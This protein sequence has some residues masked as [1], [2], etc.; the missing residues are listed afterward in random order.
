M[1][2]QPWVTI[3]T[4]LQ[5]RP[6][7]ANVYIQRKLL[8]V[9]LMT[10]EKFPEERQGLNRPF[11]LWS[12]FWPKTPVKYNQL[13]HTLSPPKLS[14]RKQPF[15]LAPEKHLPRNLLNK[16]STGTS[17]NQ[18][19]D[20]AVPMNTEKFSSKAIRARFKPAFPPPLPFFSLKKK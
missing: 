6:C 2:L 14:H 13:L 17:Y 10:R 18:K 7:L 1:H 3:P 19:S 5:R 16:A 20:P 12:A 15:P 4:V 8:T 9:K 11:L